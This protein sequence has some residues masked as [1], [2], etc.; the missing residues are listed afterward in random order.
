A[1]HPY[2]HFPYTTL[3]RSVTNTDACI[4]EGR[5]IETGIRW[6]MRY[7]SNKAFVLGSDVRNVS[8][9]RQ[10]VRY[11]VFES[12]NNCICAN[13]ACVKSRSEEHTSELQS[14]FDLV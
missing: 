1:D 14:R 6:T 11:A 7:R 2:L 10:L 3:F 9:Q 13:G 8:I 5:V 12:C 4:L